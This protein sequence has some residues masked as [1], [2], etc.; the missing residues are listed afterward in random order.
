MTKRDPEF[1]TWRQATLWKM[2]SI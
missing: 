2:A 1:R